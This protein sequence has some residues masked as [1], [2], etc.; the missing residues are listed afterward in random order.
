MRHGLPGPALGP[1]S[2]CLSR[3]FT[4]PVPWR[5]KIE[6]QPDRRALRHTVDRSI[7]C[8]AFSGMSLM[9]VSRT[10]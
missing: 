6:G 4:D 1:I 3:V 7:L 2:P 8:S 10:A 5:R 9:T